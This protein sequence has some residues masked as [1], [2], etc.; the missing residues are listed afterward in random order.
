MLFISEHLANLAS[1][2][3]GLDPKTEMKEQ[4]KGERP[5]INLN[6]IKITPRDHFVQGGSNKEI[7]RTVLISARGRRNGTCALCFSARA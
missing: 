3:A 1:V 6:E 7:A 2:L 4:A 5:M